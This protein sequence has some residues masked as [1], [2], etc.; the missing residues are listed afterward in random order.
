MR[1]WAFLAAL[2]IAQFLAVGVFI[3]LCALSAGCSADV[4]VTGVPE[5]I[6]LAA[7]FCVPP[8]DGGDQ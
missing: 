5:E 3:A 6:R 2:V 8:K 4:N 1:R 7:P